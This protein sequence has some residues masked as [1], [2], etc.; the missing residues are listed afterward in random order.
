MFPLGTFLLSEGPF[1]FHRLETNIAQQLH[2]CEP[3]GG[4]FFVLP[5]SVVFLSVIGTCLSAGLWET[6]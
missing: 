6:V 1:F 2:P 3:V 4:R 5:P